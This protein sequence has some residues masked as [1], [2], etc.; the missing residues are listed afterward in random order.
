MGRTKAWQIIGM[1]AMRSRALSKGHTGSLSLTRVSAP[2]PSVALRGRHY[3]FEDGETE[4]HR[5]GSHWPKVALQEGGS[6]GLVCLDCLDCCAVLLPCWHTG[7][8]KAEAGHSLWREFGLL[9]V[10]R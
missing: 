9:S 2:H 4:S 6:L 7:A 5:N 3:H 1:P 10:R 8:E